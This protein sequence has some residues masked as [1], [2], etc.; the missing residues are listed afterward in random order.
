M[1]LLQNSDASKK[2]RAKPPCLDELAP[3]MPE[4]PRGVLEGIAGLLEQPSA[5]NFKA[6][7]EAVVGVHRTWLSGEAKRFGLGP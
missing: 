5:P 7:L 2:P 3:Q 1:Q 6:E 4:T